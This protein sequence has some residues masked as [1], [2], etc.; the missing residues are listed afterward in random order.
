[1]SLNR[2]PLV[3]IA[4]ATPKSLPDEARLYLV[5][6]Q[7]EECSPH[8]IRTYKERLERFFTFHNS[9]ALSI[10]TI[11]KT[12][13]GQF[14]IHLKESDHSPAYIHGHYKDLRSFFNWCIREGFM[15][16]SPLCNLKAPKVPKIKRGLIDEAQKD[17][18][19]SICPQNTFLGARNAAIIRVLWSTGIRRKEL[20]GLLVDNLTWE[21]KGRIKVFGKGAKERWVPF[22]K[23]TQKAMARYLHYRREPHHTQLW[24]TEERHPVTQ[25]GLEMAMRTL[26]N[27]SNLRGKF[28]GGL[29]HVF[30]RSWAVR[31]LKN[32]KSLKEIQIIGGLENMRTLE[33]YLKDMEADDALEKD[34]E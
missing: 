21:N 10:D 13:V 26:F 33:I 20:A 11:D 14:L 12:H 25:G 22:T 18:L 16:K 24:L 5:D 32:G 3:H 8:T 31:N 7:I 27:R 2:S 19:L 15:T 30:R 9:T 28:N 6:R 29:F 23:H 17:Q 1:M 4:S 34:W